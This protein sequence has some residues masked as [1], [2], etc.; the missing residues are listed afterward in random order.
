MGTDFE[1]YYSEFANHEFATQ[2]WVNNAWVAALCIALGA[3]G[4]PVLYLLAQNVINVG[5]A[6]AL[7]VAHDRGALFF[8]LILPHGL[9]EL[10]GD[11]RRRRHGA[12]A[13]LVVDR[14]G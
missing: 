4:L 3:L 13:L 11:L 5:V 9:L 10:H 2:V 1:N 6:G 7:M 12:L 14:S 8:G